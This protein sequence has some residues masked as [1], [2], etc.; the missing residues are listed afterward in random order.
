MEIKF[1]LIVVEKTVPNEMHNYI[2]MMFICKRK[3]IRLF[4]CKSQ[5]LNIRLNIIK[6]RETV[7]YNVYIFSF[8]YKF[9]SFVLVVSIHQLNWMLI[10]KV[11]YLVLYLW[12]WNDGCSICWEKFLTLTHIANKRPMSMKK[13]EHC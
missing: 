12:I 6:T 11:D 9:N 5:H 4:V 3:Y 13:F 2:F 1:F 10:L 8:K 7:S